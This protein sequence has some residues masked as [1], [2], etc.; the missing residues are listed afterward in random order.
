MIVAVA[1]QSGQM[2]AK[3]HCLMIAV[4]R[5][6]LLS[7]AVRAQQHGMLVAMKK[8]LRSGAVTCRQFSLL[9]KAWGQH[10]VVEVPKTPSLVVMAWPQRL[11][12]VMTLGQGLIGAGSLQ[13]RGGAG[14][15][16]R[17]MLVAATGGQEPLGI[18]ARWRRLAGTA[19]GQR[20]EGLVAAL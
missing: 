5:W 11:P 18:A 15:W 12:V 1:P 10:Q 4:A 20:L 2:V 3:H 19:A 6:H 17:L 13:R 7:L 9:E 8:R 16:R 14:P